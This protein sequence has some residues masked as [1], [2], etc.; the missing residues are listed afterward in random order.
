[1]TYQPS[2]TGRPTS[3]DDAAS[4][5]NRGSIMPNRILDL[6]HSYRA[7]RTLLSAIELNVF[8]ILAERPLDRD[9]LGER[10]GIHTR[11]A[12]DFFDSLVALRMLLRDKAGRY[13]NSAETD[14]YLDRN[15]PTYVGGA[16]EN[17]ITRIYLDWG[18]LTDA[19]RTGKPQTR[20]S[21]VTKFTELYAD[22]NLR[23]AFTNT[24]TTR[25][26][27]VAKALA[28][29]FPWREHNTLID[30]G[31]AQGC[32]PL[33]I[34]KVHPHISGGAFDLPQLQASFDEFVKAHGLAARLRF[35]PGDFFE[36]S[37]PCADVLVLGRV[38]HNWDLAIKR[39]L[40]KKAYDALPPNGALIIYEQFIDD[41]RC[42]NTDAL[43][44]SL[45][46]LLSGPGGFNFTSTDC[47]GWM[48]ETGF[49][50]IR[51]EALTADQSMVIGLKCKS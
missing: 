37:L 13:S 36:A 44:A 6:G 26:R 5:V 22:Q 51:L 29:K 39:M 4:V 14:L 2:P 43:L 24:M 15:K 49:R 9:T 32:L 16:F 28:K 38:L 23:E 42:K 50:D 20:L 12:R 18:S 41:E 40:L 17:V 35:Y 11:G 33:E 46:M 21:M 48:Q 45:Q 27:P 7:C 25:T 34:V 31:G 19:L 47:I 30:I 3:R 10:V 8:T 1:M